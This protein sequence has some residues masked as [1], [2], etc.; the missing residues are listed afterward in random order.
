M[1]TDQVE[2][3]PTVPAGAEI[4][5]EASKDTRAVSSLTRKEREELKAL[6]TKAYG[7]S[8]RWKT[9]LNKGELKK[10]S[11]QS[12][13]GNVME[14]NRVKY[15]TITQVKEKMEQILKDREEQ[16]KNQEKQEEKV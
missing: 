3:T 5:T 7:V 11:V 14:V 9:V 15:F 12:S 4:V 13:S 1:S 6:S 16:A 10:E 2:I 8:S